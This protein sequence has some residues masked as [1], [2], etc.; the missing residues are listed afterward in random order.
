MVP[1]GNHYNLLTGNRVAHTSADAISDRALMMSSAE[2]LLL[3]IDHSC[4]HNSLSYVSIAKQLVEGILQF[5]H[6][7]KEAR[8]AGLLW[9]CHDNKKG[10]TINPS[11]ARCTTRN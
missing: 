10:V 3:L 9:Q 11:R 4:Q 1:S 8:N 7:V 5:Q 2:G 6:D